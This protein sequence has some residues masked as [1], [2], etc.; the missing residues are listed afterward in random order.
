MYYQFYVNARDIKKGYIPIYLLIRTNSVLIRRI[1]HDPE[2]TDCR[3]IY[4]WE[5]CVYWY[6][7]HS[8]VFQATFWISSMKNQSDLICEIL[9]N[10]PNSKYQIFLLYV[11]HYVIVHQPMVH[12]VLKIVDNKIGAYAKASLHRIAYAILTFSILQAF[13]LSLMI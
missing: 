3:N 11:L 6:L 10:K 1:I 12:H 4:T 13:T 2:A 9:L 5:L 7:I 8:V